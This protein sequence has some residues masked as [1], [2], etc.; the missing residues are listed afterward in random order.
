MEGEQ[1]P[2]R[3]EDERRLSAPARTA[4]WYKRAAA[5]LAVLG[6]FL[7]FGGYVLEPSGNVGTLFPVWVQ[8]LGLVM[9]VVGAWLYFTTR[10]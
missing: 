7:S 9:M 2:N 6:F 10:Q 8:T 4:D 1:A 3:V 5:V